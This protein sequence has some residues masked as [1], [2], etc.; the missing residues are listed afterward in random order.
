MIKTLLIVLILFNSSFGFIPLPYYNQK[1]LYPTIQYSQKFPHINNSSIIIKKDNLIQSDLSKNEILKYKSTLLF[2][3]FLWGTN[4]S[5]IKYLDNSNIDVS[6]IS[7]IRFSLASLTL[8]PFLIGIS[9]EIILAGI[10]VGFW[11]A[12]AYI[13]QGIGLET[14][15]SNISAFICS[16]SV[17]IVPLING[18]KGKEISKYIWGACVLAIIGVSLITLPEINN[19]SSGYLWSLG[20][21]I[22][23]GIAFIKVENYLN[24]YKGKSLP[25]AAMQMLIV[26][27]SNLCLTFL[28]VKDIPDLSIL[29]EPT[30]L[31]TLLYT[32]I[33]TSALAVVLESIILS[34]VSAE[35][36][37]VILTTEP[38]WALISSTILL[39]ESVKPIGIL[40]SIMIILACY[41]TQVKN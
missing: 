41:L 15:D 26:F 40:G 10:D 9:K 11:V 22:G 28:T 4:F 8:S 7:T 39:H 31:I 12:L 6:I 16:L 36:T 3:A 32:G 13:T 34:R 1:K 14:I 19:L 20:Q 21:P 30:H 37:S 27:I 25:L 18:L 5:A 29:I 24:K 35:E 2:L 17:V 33:I 38:L 23:F